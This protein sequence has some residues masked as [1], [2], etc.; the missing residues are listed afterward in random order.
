M[1]KGGHSPRIGGNT[2]EKEKRELIYLPFKRSFRKI[3]LKSKWNTT[4]GIVPA[5]NS[6]EQRNIWKGSPV[7]LDGMFQSEIRVP[8]FQSPH[9]YQFRIRHS[10]PFFV[11]WNW[12]VQMENAIPGRILPIFN[13]GYHLPKPLPMWCVN[14]KPPFFPL[15]KFIY[16]CA[17]DEVSFTLHTPIKTTVFVS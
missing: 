8:F 4:F 14:R 10:R 16:G 6:R 7:F 3:R 12:F 5:E 11:K 13:F 2:G 17:A 15:S 1:V 9:W